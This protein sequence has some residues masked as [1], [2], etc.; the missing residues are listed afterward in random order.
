ME[1]MIR[2]NIDSVTVMLNADEFA[3]LRIYAQENGYG[4]DLES[5][6]RD[7]IRAFLNDRV[8]TNPRASFSLSQVGTNPIRIT[9]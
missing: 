9:K 5:A 4:Y 3:R 1:Q 2:S 6:L 8:G 7:R